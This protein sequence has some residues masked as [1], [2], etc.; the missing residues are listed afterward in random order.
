MELHLKISG[1]LLI[2]LACIHIIFPKY[3]NWKNEFGAVSL[4]NVQMMYVHTFFIALVLFLMGVLCLTSSTEIIG[5]TLGNRISLGFSIFW[6]IRLF[7]QF[8]GYSAKLWKG[9]NFETNMHI[10][11]TL[12]WTYLTAVFFTVFWIS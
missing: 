12:L 1:L 4:I 11:F 10:L 9:K 6:A 5:T 7:I 2:P 8:F 3:F